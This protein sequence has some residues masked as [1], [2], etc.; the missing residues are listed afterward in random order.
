MSM[1]TRGLVFLTALCT[2][3]LAG[4]ATASAYDRY[5]VNGN[6]TNCRACHGDFR[7]AA[8]TSLVDGQNWGN[9]HNLHRQTMLNGDCNTCHG[10]NTFP[11][12]IGSSTG[13]NGLAAI[14]C[15]G[16]H[17]RDEDNVAAN[18]E[19]P[20]GRGAGL[21]QHHT[22]AGIAIC[23]G[24]HQDASPAS[25]TCVGENVLPPYYATPGNQHP[26]MPTDSCNLVPLPLPG[27]ENYAG[28][29]IGLDNDGDGLYDA[30]DPSCAPCGDG[31]VNG[32]EQCDTSGESATC[33]ADCTNAACGDGKLNVSAG[34]IC[35]TGGASA[36][37]DADCTAVACGDSTVN[38]AAGEECDTG[39]ASATCD[40]DCTAVV[41]GDST[42]N[43]A[44]GETC[45]PPGSCPTSC[46]DADACTVDALTGAAASCDAACTH[47]AVSTCEDG[48][49]CCPA[50]CNDGNDSDCPAGGG[51]GSG[52]GGGGGS[53]ATGGSGTGASDTGGSG[54]G[55]SGA[56]DA[57]SAAAEESGGCGCR[58]ASGGSALGTMGLVTLLGILAIGRRRR[59]EEGAD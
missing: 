45:D 55:A 48:D 1:S 22:A 31:V 10:N 19:S 5:S 25:Y 18:P 6:A 4:M 15:L 51:G 39:G 8:Y 2:A 12:M 35:D 37:C 32:A 47:T 50:G 26:D 59:R 42:V 11:V 38:A 56:S 44:A 40:A 20:N 13:G 17:G 52:P 16:C 41:C 23:Q 24:C 49:G 46:D 53:G 14:S 34:E 7:A 54:T 21:R 58:L 29:S 9:L 3:S 33:N 36:T 43:A 27:D 30:L 57:D 28:T